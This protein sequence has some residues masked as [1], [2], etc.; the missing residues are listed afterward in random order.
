MVFTMT[1]TL[2]FCPGPVSK[3]GSGHRN[4]Q[5]AMLVGLSCCHQ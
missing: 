2:S 1:A 5:R 4:G 3:P